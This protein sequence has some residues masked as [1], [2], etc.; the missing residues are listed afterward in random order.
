MPIRRRPASRS[1]RSVTS[2][3]TRVQML[4]T[5]RRPI[6]ISWVIA[7]LEQWVAGQATWSSKARV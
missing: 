1:T 7:V 6:R 4:P 3:Q 5:V 2:A